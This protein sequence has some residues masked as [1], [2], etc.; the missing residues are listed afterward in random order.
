MATPDSALV[1][2]YRS[3]VPRQHGMR[4]YLEEHPVALIDQGFD[5]VAESHTVGGR[6]RTSTRHPIPAG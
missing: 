4:T 1:G 3:N 6:W 2:Q 5:G